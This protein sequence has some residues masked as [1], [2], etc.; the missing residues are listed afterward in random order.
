MSFW[1]W[2]KTASA[3]ANA[4]GSINWAEG[5]APSSVNDSARAMM[6][7]A[8]KFR[9]D[10]SGT[11][12]TSGTSTAYT[13][14]SNQVFDTAPHM[15]GA[16]I[17]FVPHTTSGASPTLAVDALTARAINK[18]TGVPI[19]S[20]TLIA[21][22]PYLVT[23]I[24]ATTE[25]ILVGAIG[26]LIGTLPANAVVTA[27]ILD[28]N[29][30]Y[31]KIQNVSNGK[32]LG[33]NSGAAA[34]PSEIS[35]GTGLSLS[36]ATLSNPRTAPTYQ[37][38]N[39]GSSATYTTPA[40]VTYIKV[41]MLGG[42][43]A[44]GATG[45]GATSSTAGG[46]TS[47]N[48]I[49]AN[50]GAAGN[51]NVGAGP[52]AGSSASGTGTGRAVAETQVSTRPAPHR[53]AAWAATP[54]SRVRALEVHRGAPERLLKQT[55]AQEAAAQAAR[56]ARMAVVVAVVPANTSKSLSA[57][58]RPPT[59]TPSA[60]PAPG[61]LAALAAPA[62]ATAPPAALSSKNITTS[63]AHFAVT[64][65]LCGTAPVQAGRASLR[66]RFGR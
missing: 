11:L 25:F 30:T 16:L 40:N 9:D 17:C 49:V 2:S 47:F 41:R 33:N 26:V 13:L 20:G 35:V 14:A 52:G 4:D 39:S 59:P 18:S 62:G 48:S 36:G 12:T 58:R 56:Q 5:M 44:G 22:T 34:S 27:S 31:A 65:H 19:A 23:Y 28:A 61:V 51:N 24:H 37:V 54:C 32:L 43:G 63:R 6:A 3:N 38:L 66:P 15:N 42:G 10:I 29:V 7:A 64:L 60:Q 55:R 21:G 1:K 46:N 45:A 50:G 57:R 53:R 8:A